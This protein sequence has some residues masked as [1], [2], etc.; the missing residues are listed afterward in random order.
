MG[1]VCFTGTLHRNSLQP[2]LPPPASLPLGQCGRQC[3]LCPLVRVFNGLGLGG[4]WGKGGGSRHVVDD[5][6]AEG[7]GQQRPKHDPRHNQHNPQCADY[8]ALPTRKRH[9]TEQR[10]QRPSEHSDPTQHAKGRTGD[11][12]GPR[13]ETATRWNVTRGFSQG[14]IGKGGGTPLPPGCPAYAQPLSP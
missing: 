3:S 12:P 7:S 2:R 6:N 9:H 13:K 5:L 14:C 8:W 10:P 4:C 1:P 11:C